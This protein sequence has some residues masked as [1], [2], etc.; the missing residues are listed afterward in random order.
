MVAIEGHP[1]LGPQQ[2]AAAE[3]AEMAAA[4][5]LD[6]D[7]RGG[8]PHS[9]M[10][11]VRTPQQEHG[12]RLDA[13]F[14]ISRP[15]SAASMGTLPSR[16]GSAASLRSTGTGQSRPSSAASARS[17]L[18]DSNVAPRPPAT[19]VEE[20]LRAVNLGGKHSSSGVRACCAL[21]ASVFVLCDTVLQGATLPD[22][23]SGASIHCLSC[24]RCQ[25]MSSGRWA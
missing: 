19:A 13:D 10:P 15:G 8:A 14:P 1:R 11:T 20:W 9:V 25:R 2:A 4:H 22:L 21:I 16:P 18:Y 6:F 17:R 12:L 23:P 5:G 3:R 7:K 24:R